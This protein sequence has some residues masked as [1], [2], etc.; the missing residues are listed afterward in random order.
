MISVKGTVSFEL[1]RK[2][3]S[4]LEWR[5][6]VYLC[7]PTVLKPLRL[8][9]SLRD[10]LKRY[11]LSPRTEVC[12]GCRRSE[13]DGK[14]IRHYNGKS[15]NREEKDLFQSLTLWLIPNQFELI[16]SLWRPHANS[17]LLVKTTKLERGTENAH[18][19]TTS[20]IFLPLYGLNSL[21]QVAL[22]IACGSIANV[23]LLTVV[24]KG[25]GPYHNPRYSRVG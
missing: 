7:L 16:W 14:V 18:H 20:T 9:S 17:R 24:N 12:L 23:Y 11:N 15:W 3:R 1:G 8:F 5:K 2:R 13:Q 25:L 10:N 22:L 6:I 21:Y 19:R 4:R